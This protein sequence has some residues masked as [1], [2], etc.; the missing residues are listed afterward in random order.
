MATAI[1]IHPTNRTPVRRRRRLRR[2]P[3]VTAAPPA[4][5]E[6]TWDNRRPGTAGFARWS[7]AVGQRIDQHGLAE[8]TRDIDN[9][10]GVARRY[11]VSSTVVDVLADP[12]EP[13]P[14]RLRAI[15]RIVSAL[16]NGERKTSDH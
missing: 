5:I 11:G 3:G 12:S 1:V 9:L 10:V 8:S 2:Y 16:V 7:A 15:A 4:D 14:A 6:F 13:D